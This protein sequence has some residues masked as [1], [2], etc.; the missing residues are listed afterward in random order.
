MLAAICP[1]L[2][3]LLLATYHQVTLLEYLPNSWLF[4]LGPTVNRQCHGPFFNCVHLC[5]QSVKK[6]LTRCLS[7]HENLPAV[8]SA[9]LNIKMANA[10]PCV[11]FHS[12]SFIRILQA[13]K[14]V[15]KCN[16]LRF[17]ISRLVC[18]KQLAVR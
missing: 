6:I 2:V 10:N 4:E 5:L 14:K 9:K 12:F 17:H 3:L 8:F 18:V 7:K 1:S 15:Q 13:S 16:K 11:K